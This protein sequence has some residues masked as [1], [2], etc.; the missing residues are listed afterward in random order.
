MDVKKDILWRVTV[1]YLCVFLFAFIIIC[2]VIYLQFFERDKW[3]KANSLTT[4]DLILKPNRGDICA[5]DGRLL[6]SSVPYYEIR[7]D[8]NSMALNDKISTPGAATSIHDP[9]LEKPALLS[10]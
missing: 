9:Q 10:F 5:N 4:K 3:N 7:M 8:M 1:I 2:K 6:A